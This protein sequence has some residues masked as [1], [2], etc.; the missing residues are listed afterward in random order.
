MGLCIPF[1]IG[2]TFVSRQFHVANHNYFQSLTSE[3][4]KY[5]HYDNSLDIYQDV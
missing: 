2:A 4:A 3:L 5:V 1:A